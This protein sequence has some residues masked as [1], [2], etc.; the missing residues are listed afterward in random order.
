MYEYYYLKLCVNLV[1]NLKLSLFSDI[2]VISSFSI[3]FSISLS[4][5]FELQACHATVSGA[6]A[7]PRHCE[8]R[9][10]LATPLAV[11]PLP[12]HATMGGAAAF[13]AAPLPVAPQA[14]HSKIMLKPLLKCQLNMKFTNISAYNLNSK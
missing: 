1:Y 5:F 12:C 4:M 9:R 3:I 13:S 11:A 2:F 7:L 14:W 8:W 10:S 6:A